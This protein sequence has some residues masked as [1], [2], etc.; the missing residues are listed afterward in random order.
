MVLPQSHMGFNTKV[1]IHDLDDLGWTIPACKWLR[2]P[3]ALHKFPIVLPAARLIFWG[4]PGMSPIP[5]VKAVISYDF[6]MV[7][8]G[9]GTRRPDGACCHPLR[10]RADYLLM[11]GY[12]PVIKHDNWKSPI[13]G[14]FIGKSSK[15]LCVYILYYI[16]VC[17]SV[18]L[19]VCM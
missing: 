1:V 15:Y 13:N 2:S 11:W 12:P 4:N 19:Y 5:G 10:R 7:H 18:C 6:F 14:G 8:A 9:E 16:Y 3:F 17:M